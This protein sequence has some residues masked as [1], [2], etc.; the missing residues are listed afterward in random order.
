MSRGLYTVAEVARYLA[1]RPQEVARMIKDD[2]LPAVKLPSAKREVMKITLH[3]LHEW[4]SGRHSGAR[5]M[6]V[7]DL[8]MEIEA[9]NVEG[10]MS[11]VGMLQLRSAVEIIFQSVKAQMEKEA[12]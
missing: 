4:M 10:S 11:K 12:A 3:G 9:A 2:A 5:F 8:A 7:E 6:S 1:M